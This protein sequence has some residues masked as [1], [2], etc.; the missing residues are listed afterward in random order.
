MG[1]GA[2]EGLATY[3]LTGWRD[4]EDTGEYNSDTACDQISTQL[5]TRLDEFED[6]DEMN[7]F[8]PVR[9]SGDQTWVITRTNA[10]SKAARSAARR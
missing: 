4:G 6:T 5:H 9:R 2:H 1:W 8:D 10:P 7:D 3:Y